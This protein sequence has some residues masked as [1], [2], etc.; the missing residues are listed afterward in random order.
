VELVGPDV[1]EQPAALGGIGQVGGRRSQAARSITSIRASSGGSG[2]GPVAGNDHRRGG[3]APAGVAQLVA[4]AI[5]VEVQAGAGARLEG[6]ER[7]AGLGGDGEEAGQQDGRAAHLVGLRLV[8]H[9]RLDGRAVARERGLR[10][11]PGGGRVA[12][13]VGRFWKGRG[14]RWG[15][16]PPMASQVKALAMRLGTAALKIA[17]RPVPIQ[18]ASSSALTPPASKSSAM[19]ARN[20][21]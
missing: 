3:I 5:P 18:A 15:S 20:P 14:E 10:G 4:E 11:R 2:P 12:G 1:G 16:S 21:S 8:G 6:A 13:T 19:T 9:E 17:R 7:Q